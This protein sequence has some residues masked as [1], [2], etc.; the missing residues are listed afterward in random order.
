VTAL[1]GTIS[2]EA[3]VPLKLNSLDFNPFITPETTRKFILIVDSFQK[4]RLFVILCV[5]VMLET[6]L[7][8]VIQRAPNMLHITSKVIQ[9]N[10]LDAAMIY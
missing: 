2:T 9:K 1:K 4:H 6:G 5:P 3:A 10:Q 8:N 7:T